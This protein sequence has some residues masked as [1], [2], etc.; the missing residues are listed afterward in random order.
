MAKTMALTPAQRQVADAYAGLPPTS[1]MTIFDDLVRYARTLADPMVSA[2]ATLAANHF[3]W[4]TR[5]L[6][7]EKARG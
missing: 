1:A 5:A 2:G 6:K 4:Q 3:I 7:R